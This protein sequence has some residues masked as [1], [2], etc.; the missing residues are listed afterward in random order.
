MRRANKYFKQRP[1]ANQTNWRAAVLALALLGVTALCADEA[2]QEELRELRKQNRLLQEQLSKQQQIID[3]LS[4]K[5][6]GIER[7]QLTRDE[8]STGDKPSGAN[9]IVQKISNQARVNISGQVAAGYFKTGADGQH[10]HGEFRLDEARIFFD[11]KVW[12]DV[13]G[14][15]EVNAMTREGYDDGVR[16]GEAYI[17]FERVLKWNDLE[18]LLN[19]RLGRFYIPFGEEYSVRYAID[20][21][22][23]LHSLA[24]FWGVDEGIELYG[25]HG[26][27]QYAVAVQNGGHSPTFEATSDKSVTARITYQPKQ[28][29]K[30]SASGFRTG[31][32]SV[33]EEGISEMWF[34][35]GFFRSLGNPNT[36]LFHADVAEG[37]VEFLFSKGH[38]KLTGG[39]IRYDDNDRAANNYRDAYFYSA[40]GVFRFA[41]KFYG[42]ARY[43]QI[44]ADK[45]L[46][47][48][49]TGSWSEYFEEELTENLWRLSLGL[50]FT[51]N[52]NLVFKIEY[53]FERGR[54]VGGD[55]RNHEDF[56]G[57][58]A[59][60]RF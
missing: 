28:W 34:A 56:F 11:A 17:D 57:A 8:I 29:L 21:P 59:A 58:Q 48:V 25:S 53:A 38:L 10:P 41:K 44:I 16:L 39:G 55:S 22:L 33:E 13:Y 37:D 47:L 50:G 51:P 31:D 40:E 15:V 36:T 52:P 4:T 7:A 14:Y 32:L 6:A 46:P 9:S 3:S 12:E 23:I 42:A 60:L 45:G 5:V 24:D 18:S 35:N 43:S 54:E 19:V 1:R 49:G 20:N 30:V 26:P 27:V 2:V